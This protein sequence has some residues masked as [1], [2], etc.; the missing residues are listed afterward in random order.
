MK[1][2]YLRSVLTFQQKLNEGWMSYILRWPSYKRFPFLLFFTL[3]EQ[4]LVSEK[5]PAVCPSSPFIWLTGVAVPHGPCRTSKS[6]S[7]CSPTMSHCSSTCYLCHTHRIY[8]LP[9]WNLAL[10]DLSLKPRKHFFRNIW[11]I[12]YSSRLS[13][14]FS[15]SK[16]LSMGLLTQW[17][18]IDQPYSQ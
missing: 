18:F 13:S 8:F 2:L 6:H 12:I 9:S 14:F 7:C 11:P 10:N 3:G 4:R 17:S 15:S 5:E 16:I 1:T